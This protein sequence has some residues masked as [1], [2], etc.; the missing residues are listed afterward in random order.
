MVVMVTH[1]FVRRLNITPSP[2]RRRPRPVQCPSSEPPPAKRTRVGVDGNDTASVQIS[3]VDPAGRFVQVKN[4]SNQVGE[5]CSA[6]TR[7]GEG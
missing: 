2:P 1:V 4:M 6:G 5:K 7:E 3:D